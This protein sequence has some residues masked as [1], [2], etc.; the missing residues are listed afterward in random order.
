MR[1]KARLF[2]TSAGLIAVVAACGGTTHQA[3]PQNSVDQTPAYKR[4]YGIGYNA[5]LIGTAENCGPHS[6]ALRKAGRLKTKAQVRDFLLGCTT[7]AT[8][9]VRTK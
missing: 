8:D 6:V 5:V 1:R 3:N 4:G 9:A 2:A 7:G